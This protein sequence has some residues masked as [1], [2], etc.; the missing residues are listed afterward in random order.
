MM[1]SPR[2]DSD[3]SGL[4]KRSLFCLPVKNPGAIAL[5]RI[6]SPYFKAISVASECVKLSITAFA[7]GYPITRVIVY[8]AAIDE[9]LMMYSDHCLIMLSKK[10]LRD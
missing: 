5:A 2:F 7:A 4:I 3:S 10:S 1:V 8:L 9:I 6:P